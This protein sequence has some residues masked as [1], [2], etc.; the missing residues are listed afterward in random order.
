MSKMWSL[1]RIK[2]TSLAPRVGKYKVTPTSESEEKF[3]IT[4]P[5]LFEF[6]AVSVG[7]GKG[8]M[9][10]VPL[11]ESSKETAQFILDAVKFYAEYKQ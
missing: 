7:D 11:D 4:H 10:L 9:F 2:G 8:Q 1:E 3:K 6:E 5:H